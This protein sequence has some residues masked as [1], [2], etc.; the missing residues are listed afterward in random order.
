MAEYRIPMI[1]LTGVEGALVRRATR[2]LL[3]D[4]PAPLGVM[5]HNK[6][7]L[8]GVLGMSRKA[9]RWHECDEQLKVLAHLATV[10]LVG[11]RF[12]VDVGYF[13]AH[14]DGLDVAKAREALRWRESE[15]FSPLERD[16]LEYAEAVSRT[17]PTVTDELSGRLLTELGAPAL[18]E[19]TTFVGLA[20]LA[21]RM[22]VAIGP[23]ASQG[24]SDRCGL[25]ALPAPS[26]AAT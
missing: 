19:L 13:A 25:P 3:G 12:C 23:F 15:A 11:C 8:K 22:N 6:Q 14:Q 26:S 18:L 24:F 21:A 10:A 1:E 7:V 9:K 16:V 2:K 4:V 20:N 17:P 5:W